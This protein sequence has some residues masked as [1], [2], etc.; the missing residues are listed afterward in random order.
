MLHTSAFVVLL[1]STA[2][3]SPTRA[4][5]PAWVIGGTTNYSVDAPSG[6]GDLSQISARDWHITAIDISGQVWCWG[7]YPSNTDFGENTVPTNLGTCVAIAAGGHHTLAVTAAGALRC[8]GRNYAGECDVPAGIALFPR[9]AAGYSHCIAIEPDGTL[10]AWGWNYDG[11]TSTPA[12]LG[13]CKQVSAGY[14]HTVAVRTTGTVRCWGRND[15]GQ[16]TPPADLSAITKTASGTVHTLALNTAGQVRAW[17]RNTNGE[18]L[19]PADLPRVI[20]IA[21]GGS[22]SAVLTD[23]GTVIGWG[24]TPWGST[25]GSSPP[26]IDGPA[27]KIEAGGHYDY[28]GGFLAAIRG[29]STAIYGVVPVSG[30][31]AGGTSVTI[32][33]ANFSPNPTVRFGDQL[34]QTATYLSPT[35]ISAVTPAGN[36]GMCNV[37]VNGSSALA[38]YYRPYCG[39]DLDQDGE[40][41]A[42]DISIVLLDFG[43]CYQTPLTAP[44]PEVPPL[45]DA[46]A[47]P[48]AARHR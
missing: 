6:V 32:T 46:Q 44:A 35:R 8:W 27:S 43:P 23:A 39:S 16:S 2:L 21:G 28:A 47:L 31:S 14:G 11:Q 25:T 29:P 15:Y 34:A 17:G 5:G 1:A 48:D 36:P 18:S 4:D 9:I 7:K 24:A 3:T 38:F 13:P 22:F 10:K 19:V 30:P 12:D 37:T 33:G 41:T 20:D 45:L 42:A 26:N 40:V